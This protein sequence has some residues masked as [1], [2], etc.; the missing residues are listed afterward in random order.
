MRCQGSLAEHAETTEGSR[1]RLKEVARI[2]IDRIAIRVIGVVGIAETQAE[3]RTTPIPG[4]SPAVAP[5]PGSVPICIAPAPS[6]APT[7]SPAAPAA[8]MAPATMTPAMTPA[9]PTPPR[10]RGRF[11][12][13]FTGLRLIGLC[14]LV[15][16]LRSVGRLWREL[17]DSGSPGGCLARELGIHFPRQSGSC[18]EKRRGQARDPSEHE[19]SAHSF[20]LPRILRFYYWRVRRHVQ[21]VG[22]HLHHLLRR[23]S[24]A[25][26]RNIPCFWRCAAP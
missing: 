6:P 11:G 4:A 22:N 3:I 16:R 26:R 5:A 18:Q 13:K 12:V 15:Q 8:A 2:A 20:G 23:R 24:S 1:S 7:S 17:G 25:A 14:I 9:A 10:L 19:P 21:G